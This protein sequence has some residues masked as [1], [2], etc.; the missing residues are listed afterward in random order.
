MFMKPAKKGFIMYFDNCR[1]LKKLQPKW[2]GEVVLALGEY[3]ERLGT[4][5][6]AETYLQEQLARMPKEAAVALDFL[7]DDARRDEGKYQSVIERRSRYKEERK[8]R[9]AAPAPAVDD[10]IMKYIPD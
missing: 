1:R 9:P 7:A 8:S 3:A 10:D 6:N 2:R 5:E 4:G